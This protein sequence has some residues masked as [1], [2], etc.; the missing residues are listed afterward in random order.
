[1]SALLIAQYMAA[2]AFF[3]VAFIHTLVWLKS[4]EVATQ[5]CFALTAVAAGANAIAE[6]SMYGAT[7]LDTMAV[8][9]KWYVAMSGIWIIALV[10]FVVAYTQLGKV[11]RR[12]AVVI[13]AIFVAGLVVNLFSTSSFIYTEL[14]GLREIILPWGDTIRLPEGR[15]SP[16]RFVTELSFFGIF[17]LVMAGWA[18]MCRQGQ[19]VRASFFTGGVITFLVFFATHAFLVDTGRVDSPYLSSYAFLAI[20][21]VMSYDLAVS[22]VRSAVL[23]AQ[24]DTKEVE[25][26]TAVTDER[27]RI[28]N[29]LHDSVTQ[30]LFST[31]AI[32][33]A[34]PDV[35]DRHPEEARRGL[36]QLRQLTKSALAEMRSLLVELR[37]AALSEKSLVDLLHQLAAATTGRSTTQVNVDASGEFDIAEEVK[38]ALYRIAQEAL[39]NVLKHSAADSATLQLRYDGV[40]VVL[41]I[42][43]DGCGID[44]NNGAPDH[45][46]L[47]I[48]KDRAS[49]ID[50]DFQIESSVGEGTVVTVRY[51]NSRGGLDG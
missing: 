45:L 40:A 42:V 16:W 39:N 19:R 13:T 32:A 37:P 7:S 33:E 4:R 35:W 8:A 41:S 26:R 20:V 43:D 24:L 9:L 10:W 27:H 31:A 1:M 36:A 25:L 17:G 11:G 49:A 23:S 44:S 30:T 47:E 14:T 50:A 28:A 18:A 29:E 2:A 3:T 46:G 48:M 22:V 5:L 6:A 51:D 15:D 12:V 34:L 38:V 21:L